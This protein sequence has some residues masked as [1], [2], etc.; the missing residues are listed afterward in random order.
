M[1][2][3]IADLISKGESFAFET[4][5]SSK[6]Y[7]KLIADAQAQGYTV[8]LLYFWL[9]S[10]ELAKIRVAT[11]VKEGGHNIE[12]E[13]IER[14]YNRG[15]INL[16]EIYL[17][18]VNEAFIFDNTNGDHLLLA[19]INNTTKLEIIKN[20]NFELLKSYYDTARNA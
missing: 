2:N 9:G 8:T 5:L 17:N 15:V 10:V 13:V 11:R 7:K 3:R 4:T 20:T 19:E 16:F 12:P 6:Y 18:I 14:R 1:L